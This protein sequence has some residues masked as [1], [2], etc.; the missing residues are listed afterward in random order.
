MHGEEEGR[1]EGDEEEGHEEEGDEALERH[2]R[3]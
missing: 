1:Q 3:S 2:R